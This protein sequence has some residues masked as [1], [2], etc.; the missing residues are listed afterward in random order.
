MIKPKECSGYYSSGDIQCQLM[1]QGSGKPEIM[2]NMAASMRS[3][4]RNPSKNS[5]EV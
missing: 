5:D 4:N 1:N 2:H 3:M